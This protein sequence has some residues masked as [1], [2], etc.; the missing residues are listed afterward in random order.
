MLNCS[1]GKGGLVTCSI[2]QEVMV[3]CYMLYRVQRFLNLRIIHA[4]LDRNS[5][6]KT[7]MQNM[8]FQP[9]FC[10]FHIFVSKITKSSSQSNPPP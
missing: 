5:D 10:G 4:F 6:P 1:E 9:L 8:F 2:I 3:A 7:K